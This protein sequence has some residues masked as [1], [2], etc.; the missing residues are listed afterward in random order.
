MKFLFLYLCIKEYISG[1]FIFTGLKLNSYSEP[2]YISCKLVNLSQQLLKFLV[3]CEAFTKFCHQCLRILSYWKN[4]F[5]IVFNKQLNMQI[6]YYHLFFDELVMTDRIDS[7]LAIIVVWLIVI[8]VLDQRSGFETQHSGSQV[9]IICTVLELV[10]IRHKCYFGHSQA[11]K[12]FWVI[13]FS[14]G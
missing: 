4:E 9:K 8:G 1:Q 7:V 11:T 3:L 6:G 13:I 14:S 12:L 2:R 5:A 10:L